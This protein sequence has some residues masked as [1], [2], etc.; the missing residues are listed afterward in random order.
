MTTLCQ[1]YI[2]DTNLA[3]WSCKHTWPSAHAATTHESGTPQSTPGWGLQ[4]YVDPVFTTSSAQSPQ[5]TRRQN[6]TFIRCLGGYCLHSSVKLPVFNVISRGVSPLLVDNHVVQYFRFRAATMMSVAGHPM[7]SVCVFNAVYVI[8]HTGVSI[9][10]S[11]LSVCP[12]VG[13]LRAV[14]VGMLAF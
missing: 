10:S 1:F 12:P 13:A 9:F 7:W 4:L 8:C 5:C 14:V 6:E 11:R 3:S 2:H